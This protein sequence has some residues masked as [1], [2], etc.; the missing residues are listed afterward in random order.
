MTP[1]LLTS[2]APAKVNLTLRVRGRSP[3]GWHDLVSLV[4]FAGV[5]DHLAFVPGPDLGLEVVGGGEAVAGL[6]ALAADNLVLRAAHALDLAVPGLSIGRFVLTKRLPIAA[7]LGGGSSDA[8]AALRLLARHN[9]IVLDHPAILRTAQ[10]IGADVTACLKPLGRYFFGR[11]DEVSLRIGLPPVPA[12][13]VN[14]RVPLSTAAVFA[15]LGLGRGDDGPSAGLPDPPHRF[16]AAPALLDWLAGERND[17]EAPAAILV[18]EVAT[19]LAALAAT[20]GCRLAR[21]SG[22]GATVFGLYADRAAAAR[23]ARRIRL[24]HPAW[25][26]VSTV[27]R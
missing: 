24:A 7:G 26:A 5:G 23:A 6:P 18:P 4:A 11:G 14:P 1:P 20:D 19:A 8:A 17:L 2:R 13:L 25:W 16:A 21:M 3:Q 15:A 12:V 22:S 27:L 10:A 9:G